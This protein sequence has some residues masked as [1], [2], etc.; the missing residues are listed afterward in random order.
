MVRCVGTFL[1]KRTWV[2][3]VLNPSRSAIW[4]VRHSSYRAGD[5]PDRIRCSELQCKPLPA[6]LGGD[7]PAVDGGGLL[8]GRGGQRRGSELQVAASRSLLRCYVGIW[9]KSA[10][11]LLDCVCEPLEPHRA[12]FSCRLLLPGFYFLDI[13]LREPLF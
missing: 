10:F 4:I 11:L 5:K 3:P 12:A 9:K 13:F 1:R 7:S 8:A 6:S 2:K